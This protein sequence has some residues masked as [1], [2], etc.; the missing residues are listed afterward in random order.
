MP[1]S[2][3]N[4]LADLALTVVAENP[5]EILDV[6]CGFGGKGVL[7]RECTDIWYQRYAKEDWKTRIDAIEPFL[8][9]ITPLH[10]YIYSDVYGMTLEHWFG[11]PAR[12]NSYDF[13]YMG[14]VL[15]HMTENDGFEALTDLSAVCDKTIYIST[16]ILMHPQGTVL[17]NPLEHHLCQ[18]DK[19]M[20][21]AVPMMK[22]GAWTF[23]SFGNILV[24]IWRVE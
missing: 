12:E 7:F 5:A 15:E 16:P 11:H 10:H 19:T 4:H 8:Q 24:A 21:L 6:G 17:G 23:K 1:T 18:W 9:Y 13:I 2:R 3:P 22:A 20:F 14:D